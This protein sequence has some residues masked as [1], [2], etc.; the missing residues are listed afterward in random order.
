MQFAGVSLGRGNIRTQA[1]TGLEWA[2]GTV[3]DCACYAVC[4][5]SNFYLPDQGIFMRTRCLLMCLLG[6]G[7]TPSGVQA[8][9]PPIKQSREVSFYLQQPNGELLQVPHEYSVQ[10]TE[11]E[12]MSRNADRRNT[13]VMLRLPGAKSTIRLKEGD[14]IEVWAELPKKIDPRRIELLNSKPAANSASRTYQLLALEQ[15]RT[16]EYSGLQSSAGPRRQMA[17]RT[18]NPAPARRVLFHAAIG[19]R[20]F[21]LWRGQK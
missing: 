8:Q 2:T 20:T 1:K 14:A 12:G 7:L 18:H 19:H 4:V 21:L 10:D 5:K 6:L 16:L 17:P 3:H 9:S 15:R 11:H 13:S